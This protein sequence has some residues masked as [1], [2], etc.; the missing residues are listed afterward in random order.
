MGAFTS[1]NLHFL[2]CEMEQVCFPQTAV[3]M[4]NW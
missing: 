3:R 1:L 2:I 4:I